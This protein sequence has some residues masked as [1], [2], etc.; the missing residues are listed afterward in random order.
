MFVMI[1]AGIALRRTAPIVLALPL[2]IAALGMLW[3]YT[4]LE[5]YQRATG[6]KLNGIIGYHYSVPDWGFEYASN[7]RHMERWSSRCP[8]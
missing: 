7:D 5:H 6:R 4:A 3:M 2:L 1:I 8:R